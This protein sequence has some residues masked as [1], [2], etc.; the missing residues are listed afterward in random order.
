MLHSSA[1]PQL[2]YEAREEEANGAE[3]LLKHYVGVYDPENGKLQLVQVRKVAIRATPRSSK[4]DRV[5]ADT[6]D[7][8]PTVC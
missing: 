8:P 4:V 7:E 6:G 2:D 3:P 5:V 1:H